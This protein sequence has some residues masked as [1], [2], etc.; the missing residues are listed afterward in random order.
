MWGLVTHFLLQPFL[1]SPNNEFWNQ[2]NLLMAAKKLCRGLE[3][4]RTLIV[5]LRPL[6]LERAYSATNWLFSK[7]FDIEK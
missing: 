2:G 7:T 3:D 1:N 6:E 5:A 4:W